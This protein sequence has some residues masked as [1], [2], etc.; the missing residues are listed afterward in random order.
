MQSTLTG[1][2]EADVDGIAALLRQSVVVRYAV[3]R[4]DRMMTERLQHFRADILFW[5]RWG[6]MHRM[7]EFR[8]GR[9]VEFVERIRRNPGRWLRINSEH[10]RS[11]VADILKEWVDDATTISPKETTP[12]QAEWLSGLTFVGVFDNAGTRRV[13]DQRNEH[14]RQLHG[15]VLGHLMGQIHARDQTAAS[16]GEDEVELACLKDL[17]LLLGAM[18]AQV[19]HETM[20]NAFMS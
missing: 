12:P 2:T 10:V 9:T 19:Q 17:V 20:R 7:L 13:L 3:S 14:M 1:F 15:L 5:R 11:Q 4:P 8:I 16:E 6:F 18:V